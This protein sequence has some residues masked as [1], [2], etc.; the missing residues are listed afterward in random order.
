MEGFV[1]KLICNGTP[2]YVGSTINTLKNRLI[3]HISCSANKDTKVYKHIREIGI[4]PEIVLLETVEVDSIKE[5]RI[6]ES[7]WIKIIQEEGIK[8]FNSCMPVSDNPTK[9]NQNTSTIMIEKS[10][11]DKVRQVVKK[12]K[13]TICGFISIEVEKAADINLKTIKK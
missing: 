5:L 13:Q 1:Y 11:M 12:T 6:A 3:G 7:K 8:L 10:V 9:C 4:N 2:I